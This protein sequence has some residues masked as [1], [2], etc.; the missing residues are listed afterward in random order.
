MHL[1]EEMQAKQQLIHQ[2]LALINARDSSMQK[3]IKLNG[4]LVK[5]PKE[6]AYETVIKNH[7]D[8][9]QLLQEEKIGLAEKAFA[10]VRLT[11]H[12]TWFS[13]PRLTDLAARETCQAPRH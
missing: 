12:V 2:S 8:R 9:A 13:E 4:G 7:Y 10:L 1:Y 3:F 6:E 11:D 5:N